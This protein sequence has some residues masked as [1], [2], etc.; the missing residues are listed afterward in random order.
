MIEKTIA[1]ESLEG[2]HIY[3]KHEMIVLSGLVFKVYYFIDQDTAHHVSELPVAVK[4][5]HPGILHAFE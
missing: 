2:K 5:L 1:I 4:V 3:C